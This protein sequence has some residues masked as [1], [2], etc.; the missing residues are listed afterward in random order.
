MAAVLRDV[1]GGLASPSM[2][3]RGRRDP[4]GQSGSDLVHLDVAALVDADPAGARDR[5][6]PRRM[7]ADRPSRIAAAGRRAADRSSRPAYEAS[8]GRPHQGGRRSPVGST[9]PSHDVQRARRLRSRKVRLWP[10]TPMR[11][12]TIVLGGNATRS[13]R[14]HGSSQSGGRGTRRARRASVRLTLP[15][16]GRNSAAASP[17]SSR[18][19]PRGVVAARRAEHQR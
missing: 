3:R 9:P 17:S 6:R 5:A 10:K 12:T 18:L 19:G 13:V 11:S 16:T 7:Q 4:H 2:R 1:E 14:G 15:S 8:G